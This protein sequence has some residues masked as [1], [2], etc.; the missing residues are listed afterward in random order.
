MTK[1]DTKALIK[2][3]AIVGN[4]V[5]VL[6]ILYNGIDSGFS[7]RPVEVLSFIGLI[8][9]LLLNIYLLRQKK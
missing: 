2:A 6:W 3:V 4:A 8:L 1:T 5:Y 9:L 7:G